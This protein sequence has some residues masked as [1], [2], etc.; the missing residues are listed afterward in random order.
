MP[1]ARGAG[2]PGD[3]Q[4][5]AGARELLAEDLEV[6]FIGDVIEAWIGKLS[7]MQGNEAF[8]RIV[9]LLSGYGLL[10]S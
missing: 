10:R 2:R 1:L 5:P 6:V 7:H 3:R 8:V 9:N 4:R